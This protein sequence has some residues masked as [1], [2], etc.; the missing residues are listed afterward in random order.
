MRVEGGLN[1][2]VTALNTTFQKC[3]RRTNLIIIDL[4]IKNVWINNLNLYDRCKSPSLIQC[5]IF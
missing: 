3:L 1:W 2:A 5:T 4:V